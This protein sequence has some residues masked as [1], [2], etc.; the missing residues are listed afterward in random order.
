MTSREDLV[1]RMAVLQRESRAA[2]DTVA[3]ELERLTREVVQRPGFVRVEVDDRG[4]LVRLSVDP[5]QFAVVTPSA[6]AGATAAA[7]VTSGVSAV[8]DTAAEARLVMAELLQGVP[9][10][11]AIHDA[12][13]QAVSSAAARY[14]FDELVI[15]VDRLGTISLVIDAAWHAEVTA[16]EYA[17]VVTARV[18]DVLGRRASLPWSR[19]PP[20]PTD[21][22]AEGAAH[23]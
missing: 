14:E 21:N 13:A 15:E 1:A 10:S 16:V 3:A 6:L 18:N 19:T 17:E 12:A 9:S 7:L 8:P 5:E 22:D 4:T 2:A 20:P 11:R 23:E